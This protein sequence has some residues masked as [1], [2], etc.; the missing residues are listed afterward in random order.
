MLREDTIDRLLTEVE[1]AREELVDFVAELIRIPTVNPPGEAYEEC[2]QAIGSRLS[3]WGMEVEYLE[4]VDRPE[5][6]EAHPRVN[7]LGRRA[8]EEAR[9]LLHLNGHFDVVPPG[10]GWTLDPFKGIVR[11]GRIYGRGASDM[12]SGL[13]AAAFAL[14][15]LR[16][17]GV[18]L[19]G[20]IELSATVDEESG[21]MAGVA[22]LC[23]TG[24][25]SSARTDYVII[26]E[27]FGPD[28]ICVGHK[29][30]YW[31]DVVAQGKVAPFTLD[32]GL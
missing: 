28:R 20:T 19:R 9:P 2:A 15:C 1:Q 7:V 11:N 27:P 13:G 6:T 5:N 10:E 3:G 29:G 16:R 8:G 32:C 12:K 17:T 26:P 31:F 25:I 21:G 24:H 4:P 18:D 22:S 30:V 23:R 14:E